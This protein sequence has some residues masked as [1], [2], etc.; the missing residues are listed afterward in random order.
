MEFVYR[1]VLFV[2]I[3]S[4]AALCFAEARRSGALELL[5]S[6]PLTVA[7]ILR[8][9]WL[10]IRRLFLLPFLLALTFNVVSVYVGLKGSG[11]VVFHTSGDL[12]TTTTSVAPAASLFLAG[13]PFLT[14]IL[15]ALL[16]VAVLAT[17]LLALVW[18][19]MWLS[20]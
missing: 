19:G 13:D 12:T 17:D 16:G 5:L 9:Q 1:A 3:T 7:D 10:A 6:T 4:Q 14:Q 18:F 8:G 2:W 20:Q 15:S 11:P